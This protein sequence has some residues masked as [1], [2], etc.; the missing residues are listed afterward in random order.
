MLVVHDEQRLQ[1]PQNSR[2]IVLFAMNG[3][4]T[5]HGG[6]QTTS[7]GLT[8]HAEGQTIE[9]GNVLMVGDLDHPSSATAH[10]SHPGRVL[11]DPSRNALRRS[12][13]DARIPAPAAAAVAAGAGG[14][15][16]SS[17]LAPTPPSCGGAAV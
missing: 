4:I 3:N 8:L 7:S 16:S 10:P 12:S 9:V 17:L 13:I 11:R 14:K 15:E 6:G 2:A 1:E 5:V